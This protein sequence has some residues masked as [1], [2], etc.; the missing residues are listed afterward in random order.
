[1]NLKNC[2]ADPKTIA[3]NSDPPYQLAV[4]VES[5]VTAGGHKKNKIFR[6]QI[7][8]RKGAMEFIAQLLKSSKAV[9]GHTVSSDEEN[10][11]KQAKSKKKKTKS[12]QSSSD[13]DSERE[14]T[15]PA[16]EKKKK[17]KKKIESSTS[18]SDDPSLDRSMSSDEEKYPTTKLFSKGKETKETKKVS[19][20]KAH[21]VDVQLVE[22]AKII[23]ELTRKNEELQGK[24]KQAQ[25]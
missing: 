7:Q 14:M 10:S 9:S 21:D 2:V 25:V 12:K 13:S 24:L 3:P 22:A 18:S 15:S 4:L 19:E 5:S 1:L 6:F 16:P 17:G 11:S 20:K 23:S 8:S